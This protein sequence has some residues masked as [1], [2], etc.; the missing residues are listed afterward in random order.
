[1]Q[2]ACHRKNEQVAGC[3]NRKFRANQWL[4]AGR[5]EAGAVCVMSQKVFQAKGGF[6]LFRRNSGRAHL[7]HHDSCRYVCNSRA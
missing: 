7:A 1:M 5:M 2:T 3:W 6:E 4:N